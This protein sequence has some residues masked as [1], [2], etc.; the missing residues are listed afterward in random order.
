MAKYRILAAAAA[1]GVIAS[2]DAPGRAARTRGNPGISIALL[3]PATWDGTGNAPIGWTTP[4][5][6]L[7]EPSGSRIAIVATDAFASGRPEFSSAVDQL[8]GDWT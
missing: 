5:G 4:V 3:S 2:L 8:P 7:P 6:I 1:P